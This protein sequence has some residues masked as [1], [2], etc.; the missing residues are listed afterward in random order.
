MELDILT[1]GQNFYD[2]KNLLKK[3]IDIYPSN[4]QLSLYSMDS[5][6]HD[7]ITG[8]KGSQHKI[9][10][11]IKELIKQN[12]HVTITC[13]QTSYNP[14]SYIKVKEF[15]QSIK[16]DFLTDCRFIYNKKSKNIQAKLDKNQ[17]QEYYKNTINNDYIRNFIKD[18]KYIC[19]A[20]I[21]EISITPKLD[22]TPCVYCNYEFGNYKNLSLKELKN[23]IIPKYKEKFIRKNLEECFNND[24]C[25][26]CRYCPT[27]SSLD[28]GFMKKSSFLCEDAKAYYE[29]YMQLKNK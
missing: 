17:I 11:V 1:N 10:S 15:A 22:I 29:A 20:G 16:V 6:I 8:V 23:K 4:V 9:L 13:F 19:E 21:L 5:E 18:D 14:E 2:D 12:I 26:F 24:Y 28:R 3:I 27:T 7:Y 25:R